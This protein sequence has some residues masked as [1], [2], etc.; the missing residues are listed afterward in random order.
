[1]ENS[2]KKGWSRF[3]LNIDDSD[4]PFPKIFRIYQ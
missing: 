4:I 1:M 3:K 2:R